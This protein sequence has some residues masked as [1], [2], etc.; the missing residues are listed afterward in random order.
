MPYTLTACRA[1]R[2][3]YWDPKFRYNAA[4]FGNVR[5]EPIDVVSEVPKWFYW[6]LSGKIRPEMKGC[7]VVSLYELQYWLSRLATAHVQKPACHT[8]LWHFVDSRLSTFDQMN[9]IRAPTIWYDCIHF[10][11]SVGDN[12][13]YAKRKAVN[14]F[15]R[16]P[17]HH[18]IDWLNDGFSLQRTP[19]YSGVNIRNELRRTDGY[20]F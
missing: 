9:A 2:W 10:D 19:V 4:E 5:C 18:A 14:E 6:I 13:H 11:V 7:E 3:V 12:F 20:G 16:M 17:E 1:I 8:S 15:I